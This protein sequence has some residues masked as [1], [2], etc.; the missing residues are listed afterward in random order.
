MSQTSKFIDTTRSFAVMDP[1]IFPQNLHTGRGETTPE[2]P[3][4]TVAYAG[5]N[6]LPTAQGYRSFFGTQQKLGIDRLTARVDQLLMY[7]AV[8]L[9][10][11]LVAFTDEGI[12]YKAS[13]AVGAWTKAVS[14][15]LSQDDP[16]AE[17]PAFYHQWTICTIENKI[18]AYQE[19]RATF[20]KISST[21]LN[22]IVFTE[23]TPNF[24]NMDGQIGIFSAG[25]RLGFWDSDNSV[26]W[27]NLDD[28]TDFTPSIE[29]LAGSAKFIDVNGTIITILP[30]GDGFVIY[31]T[32]SIVWVQK[33][34]SETFQWNPV[35]VFSNNGIVFPRQAVVGVPDTT[36]YAYTHSGLYQ[37]KSGKPEVIIPE[38]FDFF[39][40]NPSPK[41]L[42]L[43]QGRY[44]CVEV[45]DANLALG[46]TIYED[47][48]TGD[49]V[50]AFPPVTSTLEAAVD[51]IDV[52][53][54]TICGL[55]KMFGNYSNQLPSSPP[56]DKKAGTFY[57]PVYK[58]YL[59][60][61]G[62]INPFT[63][64]F[65][66]AGCPI[67]FNG[68][69][70][71]M[72]P[73]ENLVDGFSTTFREILGEAMYGDGR[74]TM[75]RFVQV[76]SALWDMEAKALDSYR[77]QIEARYQTR[78]YNDSQGG[79]MPPDITYTTTRCYGKLVPAKIN[80]DY[81]F[82]ISNCGF[83]LT[84]YIEGLDQVCTK[85]ILHSEGV[86]TL[87]PCTP[88]YT[89]RAKPNSYTMI[90]RSTA[91]EL[92]ASLNSYAYTTIVSV[93]RT[94]LTP[95]VAYNIYAGASDPSV[96]Y[97]DYVYSIT[98]S[99]GNTMS[100]EVIRFCV[101]EDGWSFYTPDP[102][103]EQVYQ[104]AGRYL[105]S[106]S[107]EASNSLVPYSYG[108]HADTAKCEMIGWKYTKNDG[109]IGFIAR[110]G[111]CASPSL[112]PTGPSVGGRFSVNK[113]NG[114]LC[115]VDFEEVTIPGSPA[116]PLEWPEQTI[117]YPGTTFILRDG[118]PVPLYPTAEGSYVYDI[119][120][121][122]WGKYVGKYKHLLDY[123]PIN[124][125]SDGILDT[126]NF[127]IV[128][129]ILG[130]GGFIRLFD[131]YPSVSSITYGKIGYSRAGVTSLEEMRVDFRFPATGSITVEASMDGRFVV[132]SLT[133]TAS[134]TEAYQATLYGMYPAK[135]HQVTIN[136]W[137]DISYIE[138]KG[139]VAGRR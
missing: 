68:E 26:A 110:S 136:G 74:W 21:A 138:Y 8:D 81:Q 76:Q 88:G 14:T 69:T 35:V 3:I 70:I 54:Y 22:P 60:M 63:V 39:E 59:R 94:L 103:S 73:V 48:S 42:K 2:D 135:W 122:K 66:A 113:N 134:Y 6:F 120:L 131:T 84:R 47:G 95:T 132:P 25:S 92:E 52:G 45:F 137:F 87:R 121:K 23:Q 130:E 112:L 56:V 79:T 16:F 106:N 55:D 32:K 91:E 53:S 85:K 44:L 127:G 108:L 40:E 107:M 99:N 129:G 80:P 86:D 31:S 4:P 7:Q 61:P 98:M 30:H 93:S 117:T 9:T 105:R 13:E 109:S 78:N 19:G 38:V 10:N 104:T 27:S 75:Q 89:F 12:F 29:T 1:N 17:D 119:H 124:A 20:W 34:V 72:N 128:G 116:V 49:Y 114:S 111:G 77:N 125:N 58:A 51:A 67:V 64:T 41:Y 15:Y 18:Y 28:F 57:Q 90:N 123:S 97:K 37:I 65:D 50:L 36:H 96:G 100:W 11:I 101:V 83:T 126:S 118:S 46:K 43:L 115:G 102:R 62:V 5:Q 133:K 33:A 139:F 71:A 82:N 24:L